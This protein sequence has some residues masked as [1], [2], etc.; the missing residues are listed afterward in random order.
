MFSFLTNLFTSYLINITYNYQNFWHLEVCSIF[1]FIFKSKYYFFF[2]IVDPIDNF[3]KSS[4]EKTLGNL[5]E[6]Q[7]AGQKTKEICKIFWK[8][9]EKSLIVKTLVFILDL[10]Q[11]PDTTL[12]VITFF[13]KKL[14]LQKQKVR[15]GK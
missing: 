1:A 7:F 11:I 9:W 12:K 6:N 3:S 13:I 10:K 4:N 8:L 5:I 15:L 2:L 14:F